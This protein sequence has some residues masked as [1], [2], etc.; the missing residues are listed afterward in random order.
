M[1]DFDLRAVLSLLNSF[2]NDTR[3]LV[4]QVMQVRLHC[5][6]LRRGC[7]HHAR[8]CSWQGVLL[9]PSTTYWIYPVGAPEGA[10]VGRH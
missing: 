4:L 6:V 8:G 2:T 1:K 3:E 10:P 9:A 7:L 5:R